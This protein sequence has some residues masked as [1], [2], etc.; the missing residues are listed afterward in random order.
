[1]KIT[2]DTK[3]DSAEEIQHV[4]SFLGKFAGNQEVAKEAAQVLGE[5]L[6]SFANLF[7]EHKE[8]QEESSSSVMTNDAPP[9][10]LEL[11]GNQAKEKPPRIQII[12]DF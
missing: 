7:G 6:P 11:F 12:N 10:T 3:Q 9:P 2:I 1:M 8:Q 4:I 5:E